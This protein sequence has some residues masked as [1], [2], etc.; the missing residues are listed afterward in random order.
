MWTTY[1]TNRTLSNWLMSFKIC[2]LCLLDFD[3]FEINLHQAMCGKAWSDRALGQGP[4][5][6]GPSMDAVTNIDHSGSWRGS[7]TL[8][9]FS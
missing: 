1:P 4:G 9:L 5:R 2:L 3:S 8:Y 6:A 7:V